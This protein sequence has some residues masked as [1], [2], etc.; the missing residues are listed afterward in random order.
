MTMG[1]KKED[2]EE[3]KNFETLYYPL[4]VILAG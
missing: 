2:G 1:E 4:N 3:D